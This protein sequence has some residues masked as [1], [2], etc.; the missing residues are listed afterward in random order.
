MRTPAPRALPGLAAP[1]ALLIAAAVLAGC[2]GN[3]GSGTGGSPGRTTVTITPTVTPTPT[4]PPSTTTPPPTPPQ[5]YADAVRHLA[6]G[7]PDAA[8]SKTFASPTGNIYC[9]IFAGSGVRGCEL[10]TGRIAPPTPD[11]C[12]GTGGGGAKDIGRVEFSRAGPVAIC[13]S[14]TILKDGAPVL[15][16]GSVA[17]AGSIACISESIGMTCLDSGTK[18]GFFLARDTFFIF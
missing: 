2:S 6:T 11:Y 5:T 4:T 18:K 10:K 3:G 7:T 9:D 12:G 1:V 15:K 8:A 16:Y 13:N 17:T 14:D